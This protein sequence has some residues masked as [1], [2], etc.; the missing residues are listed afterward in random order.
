MKTWIL[1]A[2]AGVLGVAAVQ[3]NGAEPQ[4][5]LRALMK[6]K[7]E[8]SQRVLEGLA[9]NNFETVSKNASELQRI[10]KAGE[11]AVL[12]TPQYDAYRNQFR[13][14]A[15]M[16]EEMAKAKNGDGAGLVYVELTLTCLKCH[17]HVREAGLPGK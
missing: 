12:K 1:L 5:D 3:S 14:A 13:W 7:L 10:S 6:K 8:S 2:T 16:L 17:K 15:E 4:D 9:A 11:F